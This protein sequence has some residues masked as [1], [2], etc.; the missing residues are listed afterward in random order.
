[1]DNKVRLQLSPW[2]KRFVVDG[3]DDPLRIAVCGIGSGK[4]RALA[5]WI[6]LQCLQKPGLRGIVIAQIYKTLSRVLVREIQVVCAIMGVTYDYNKSAMEMTFPNDSTLFFYSAENSTGLLGLSCIDL[7]AIDE[8]AFAPEEVYNFARDR[9]RGGKY[10][11]TMTRLISSPVNDQI[12]NWFREVCNRNPECVVNA[13]TLD[14][15]FV[16]E[17]FL[18]ELKDRYIEGSTLYQ[19]QV[20]G[21]FLDTDIASQLI[22]RADFVMCKA[23]PNTNGHW[24]GADFSG[25]VGCDSDCVAVIDDTG[26]VE[27]IEDSGL[28]TQQKV[29]AI[30]MMW[31]KYSPLSAY[32][33]NTGGF[34]QG[35]I[36]LCEDKGHTL[37]KANFSAKPFNENLYPNLRTEAYAELARDIR[38]GFFIPED[39]RAE[40]LAQ[41]VTI[42][43]RGRI[44]L[45]PKELVKK[46]LGRSP[47]R[48]DAIALAN[49]ARNHGGSA[50]GA[51][52]SAKQA[53][54]VADTYL[55]MFNSGY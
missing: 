41:Q 12:E 29:S 35:A 44:A 27:I 23:N 48:S 36:D 2:Q 13:S 51:G 52:Y 45:V 15:P 1:M 34:G 21:M 4:T 38:A 49:Y 11:P 53:A 8:A 22:K 14:N 42:D 54:D 5:I 9:L 43:N 40:L 25:G 33:D 50:P 18:Q 32:G 55:R 37:N 3:F 28:N 24:L 6:V 16:S 26:V 46:Q 39:V 31:N 10:Q 17:M 20:L 7:L 19:Q 30:D 47:D